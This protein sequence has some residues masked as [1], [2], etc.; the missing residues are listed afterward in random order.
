MSGRISNTFDLMGTSWSVLKQ[1]KELLIFPFLSALACIAVMVSFALPLAN[2]NFYDDLRNGTG[3]QAVYYAI[4]FG[5]YFAT[6]FIAT[7]FNCAILGCC[8]KRMRGG[9]PTVADGFRIA[10]SRLPQILGW[11][12]FAASVGL[13]LRIIADS[14]KQIGSIV[15]SILGMAWSVLTFLVVPVLVMEGLGPIDA[16]KRSS[17]LLSQTWGDQLIGNFAFALLQFLFIIPGIIVAMFGVVQDAPAMRWIVVG[18]GVLWV[19]LVVLAFSALEMIF[20]AA[21]YMYAAGEGD[22]TAFAK[23]VLAA[24]MRRNS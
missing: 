19:V 1:D 6:Y 8:V 5:F 15:S 9:D 12:L 17:K 2:S 18:I 11:A 24:A 21:V 10:G 14:N 4:I 22:R 16:F 20:R 13:L 7:F 23:P 3:N